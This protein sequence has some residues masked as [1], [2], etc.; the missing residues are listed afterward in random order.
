MKQFAAGAAM[1]ALMC[2]SSAW[3]QPVPAQYSPDDFVKAILSGPA[4]CP[5]GKSL[6][7]CEQNPKTRRFSLPSTDD[8]VVARTVISSDQKKPAKTP[9]LAPPRRLSAGDVLLT[10]ATGSADLAPQ[11]RANLTSIAEALRRPA[12]A[13]VRFEIAGYTDI[14]GAKPLNDELSQRRA[15]SVKQFLVSMNIDP[16]RLSAVGYGSQHLA[17]PN[18]PASEA[19]RRVEMHRLN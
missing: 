1:L 16:A 13:S 4:P 19:N 2:A 14:T 12:L 8:H 9:V 3:G 7:A 10:F 6:E 18:D 17:A 5:P 11:G 15:E